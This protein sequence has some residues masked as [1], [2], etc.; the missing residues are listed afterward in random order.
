MPVDKL[1]ER[2][3]TDTDPSSITYNSKMQRVICCSECSEGS[4]TM[5]RVKDADGNRVRPA[6]YICQPCWKKERDR[7]NIMMQVL[8]EDGVV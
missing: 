3:P 1:E 4:F 7:K 5:R 8:T 6:K 2:R